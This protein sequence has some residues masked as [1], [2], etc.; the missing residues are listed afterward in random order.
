M[1]DL[2]AHD[3]INSRDTDMKRVRM[4]ESEMTVSGLAEN[5]LLFGR[6]SL[7]ESGAGKCSLVGKLTEPTTFE[8]SIIRV[9]V[10]QSLIR[11]RFVF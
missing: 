8:S 10:N 2:F 5:D 11:S 3:V 1:G 7:V 4:T 6:R 9:R